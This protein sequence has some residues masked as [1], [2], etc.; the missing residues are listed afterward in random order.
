VLPTILA[1]VST[2]S[3]IGMLWTKQLIYVLPVI[4]VLLIFQTV[5]WASNPSVFMANIMTFTA[6]LWY[7]ILQYFN[8]N[9]LDVMPKNWYTQNTIISY[10]TTAHFLFLVVGKFFLQLT[11]LTMATLLVLVTMQHVTATHFKTDG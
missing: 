4:L 8:K 6:L 11:W 7:F 5:L 1:V 10:V 3:S 9:S 2:V